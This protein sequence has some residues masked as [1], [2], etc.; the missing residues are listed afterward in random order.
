M[1]E[2]VAVRRRGARWKRFRKVALNL[3]LLATLEL[4]GTMPL[5]ILIEKQSLRFLHTPSRSSDLTLHL[6]DSGVRDLMAGIS[7]KRLVMER[8]M[9]VSGDMNV[10]RTNLLSGSARDA[11]ERG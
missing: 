3:E 10:I 4:P 9:L 5:H 8:K 11:T 6:T 7:L 1:A 2:Q